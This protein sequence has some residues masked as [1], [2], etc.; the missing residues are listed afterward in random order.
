MRQVRTFGCR[1]KSLVGDEIVVKLSEPSDD[2]FIEV[3][4]K[5]KSE[6]AHSLTFVSQR[7]ERTLFVDLL[8]E[9]G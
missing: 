8:C 9:M 4:T 2:G 1:K 7:R 3:K 5:Q 6:R